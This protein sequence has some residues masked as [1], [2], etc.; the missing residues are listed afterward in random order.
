MVLMLGLIARD[1][2]HNWER[3][4]HHLEYVDYAVAAAM[5]PTELVA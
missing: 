5:A 2:G 1:V 3:W 4:K